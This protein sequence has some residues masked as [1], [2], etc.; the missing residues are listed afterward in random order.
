MSDKKLDEYLTGGSIE[1]NTPG[2][3][4][5]IC[6]KGVRYVYVIA[7][8]GFGGGGG[9]GGGRVYTPWGGYNTAGTGGGGGSAPDAIMAMIAVT[10]KTTYNI[11]VGAGGKGGA[12]GVGTTSYVSAG[13]AGSDGADGGDTSFGELMICRGGKGGTGGLGFISLSSSSED[14]LGVERRGGLNGEYN[15]SRNVTL[16]KKCFVYAIHAGGAGGE[17]ITAVTTDTNTCK[18]TYGGQGGTNSVLSVSAG[19]GG[20]GGDAFYGNFTGYDKDG[21]KG[22][23]GVDGYMKIIW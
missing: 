1:Y 8:G 5:W 3:Y 18:G 9:G 12:G 16:Y 23:D 13:S 4:T 11:T 14:N 19:S 15:T 22:G 2:D 17:G 7:W 20:K 6:P 10:P 21:V